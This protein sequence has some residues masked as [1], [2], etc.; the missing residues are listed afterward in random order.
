MVFITEAI[1]RYTNVRKGTLTQYFEWVDFKDKYLCSTICYLNET[2]VILIGG[3]A[4]LLN[5]KCSG[6][7]K[8]QG[9]AGA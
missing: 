9:K 5:R 1:S 6:S 4:A 3:V 8:P 7:A 2:W